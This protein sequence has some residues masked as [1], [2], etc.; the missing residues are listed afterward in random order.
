[1]EQILQSEQESKL[2]FSTRELSKLRNSFGIYCFIFFQAGSLY[3]P[4]TGSVSS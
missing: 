2:S 1:M 4:Y 3:S